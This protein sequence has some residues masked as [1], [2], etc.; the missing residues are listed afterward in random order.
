MYLVQ[1][2]EADPYHMLFA[3]RLISAIT[4]KLQDNVF[5]L[6]TPTRK[7]FI[8]V[9]YH[10][11][12]SK[13]VNLKLAKE[14]GIP[15]IRRD[16]GGGTVII[17]KNQQGYRIGI[18]DRPSRVEEIYS[19]YL[20]P[21]IDVL[22]EY[23]K[24]EIRGQ[25]LLLNGKKVSGN[26]AVTYDNITC[27]TGSIIV[28]NDIAE[29]A[30][31]L[32]VSSEK[33]KDK[34]AMSIKDWVTGL[35]EEVGREVTTDEVREKLREVL[36]RKYNAKVYELKEEDLKYW[37]DISKPEE[38]DDRDRLSYVE[39]CFKVASRVFLCNEERKFRKLVNVTVRLVDGKI[40]DVTI[41]GDFFVQPRDLIE[42]LEKALQGKTPWE[43]AVV[44]KDVLREGSI[45][46]FTVDDLVSVFKD[47]GEKYLKRE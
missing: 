8:S 13:T 40:D 47:I 19:L 10:E 17:T 43:S 4:K 38:R 46:G 23:G 44:I 21:V 15:V 41:T 7:T 35:S 12:M 31:L 14:R 25:D 45:Y 37:D 1:L 5:A 27:I 11:Q 39:G 6:M 18:Y 22:K 36:L 29:L 28:K 24:V 30:Y 9:G 20:T 3:T 26:G 42:K 2:P 16:T 32:N 34:I 33:F